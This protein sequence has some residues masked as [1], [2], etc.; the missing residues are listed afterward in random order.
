M[1]GV[2]FIVYNVVKQ[3]FYEWLTPDEDMWAGIAAVI[4]INVVILCIIIWKYSEDFKLVMNDEGEKPYDKS[5][6]R[7]NVAGGSWQ[8]AD[9]KEKV[10]KKKKHHKKSHNRK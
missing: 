9:D 5:L 8:S 4:S 3:Y 7:I 6:Q 2:P 1:V 10:W